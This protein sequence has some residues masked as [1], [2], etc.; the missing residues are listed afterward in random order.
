MAESLYS[1]NKCKS[2]VQTS[3]SIYLRL[4]AVRTYAGRSFVYLPSLLE[5]D[6]VLAVAFIPFRHQSWLDFLALDM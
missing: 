4:K 5:R 1:S 3:K 6:E 2:T